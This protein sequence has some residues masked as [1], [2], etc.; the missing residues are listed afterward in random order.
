MFGV[1][2]LGSDTY[3]PSLRLIKQV[4]AYGFTVH[5]LNWHKMSNKPLNYHL[6]SYSTLLNAFML[7]QMKLEL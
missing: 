7:A 4:R 3:L 1:P 2:A 5:L 6:W